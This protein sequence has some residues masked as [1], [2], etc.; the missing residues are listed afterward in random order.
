MLI[1][2]AIYEHNKDN[3]KEALDALITLLSP[4]TDKLSKIDKDVTESS[5]EDFDLAMY[6]ATTLGIYSK[7]A[8]IRNK[9]LLD[10]NF[11]KAAFYTQESALKTIKASILEPELFASIFNKKF[12][13][14]KLKADFITFIL[15]VAG[16]GK[17]SVI[18]RS[19]LDNLLQTNSKISV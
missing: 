7:D 4:N 18:F 14:T 8:Y 19:L 2:D 16:A 3:K 13:S 12:D 10:G 15:G 17:S 5:I 11:E 1:E 6:F 9:Q